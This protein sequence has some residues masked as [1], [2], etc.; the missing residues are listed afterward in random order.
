M[1]SEPDVFGIDH[2]A[3]MPKKIEH[4]DG[5][6]NYQVRNMMRDEMQKGDRAFF[7]HS[8]CKEP[9]IVGIIR[10]IKEAYPDFTAFDPGEK[11]YDPKSDPENPRWYMV[12]VKLER[13]FKR[14]ITLQ[15]LKNYKTLA[16]M[17]ILRRGNRLSIT[18]VSK[19]QWDFILK[20]ENKSPK[21]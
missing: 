19:K 5:I 11:Y 18:P 4:W 13:K 8:N 12:D 1:K 3:K 10:V 14:V 9:G 21:N 7:Y 17:L 2:L 15:E 16:D 6:R 20:L